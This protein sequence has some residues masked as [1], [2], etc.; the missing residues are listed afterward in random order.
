MNL[1]HTALNAGGNKMI[2]MILALYGA[3][4]MPSAGLRIHTIK[5][6]PHNG[7]YGHHFTEVII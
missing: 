1:N 3:F 6:A 4:S 5:I 7:R 2:M